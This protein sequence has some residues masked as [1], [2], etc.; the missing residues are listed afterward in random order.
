MISI[1]VSTLTDNYIADITLMIEIVVGALA[2]HLSASITL[3][4][5]IVVFA[6]T[7]NS[8][9]NITLVIGVFVFA[10]GKRYTASVTLVVLILIIAVYCEHV[11][12]IR[13][14]NR[15]ADERKVSSFGI[16]E[17]VHST[18]EKVLYSGCGCSFS[19]GK[20]ELGVLTVRIS[21]EYERVCSAV[22]IIIKLDK[23]VNAGCVLCD[24]LTAVDS[25][26]NYADI[27][28]LTVLSMRC[29]KED[30]ARI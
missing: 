19:C 2:E 17:R 30:R 12:V 18:A 24:Y 22:G 26:V 21:T 11:F 28:C 14:T 6:S 8:L 10:L 9:A 3:M 7:E 4:V 25:N 1:T 27:S 5:R 20:N 13:F 23:A 15:G 29:I 16:V